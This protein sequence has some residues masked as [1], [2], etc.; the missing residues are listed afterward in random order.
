MSRP[1]EDTP[2]ARPDL[3]A[4]PPSEEARAWL[5]NE[6]RRR[7]ETGDCVRVE[8]FLAERTD[9]PFDDE[10]V[11]DLVYEEVAQREQLGEYPEVE[12]YLQRF[13][14]Q[15]E[16][17]RSLLSAH[18]VFTDHP[19]LVEGFIA[20]QQQPSSAA[21]ST[22]LYPPAQRLPPAIR[23]PGYQVEGELGRGGM[24]IVYHAWQVAL[25][26]R[27]ALKVIFA[28]RDQ[29]ALMRE[30][31]R[32]E[33]EAVARLPHANVVPIYEVGEHLGIAYYSME[34]CPGGNLAG[35]LAAT[36]Q[37]PRWSAEV[38]ATL[39][40]AMHY[41][42]EKG[43]VHDD[44]KPANV[45]LAEDGTV[46]LGD[47]GLARQMDDESLTVTWEVPGTP[48]YM[49]PEQASREHAVGPAVDIYALGAILYECLTGRPPFKA[50]TPI[51][52]IHQV[53]HVDPVPPRRLLP[54]LPADLE[55]ICLKC[56][57]KDPVRRYPTALALAEE[58]ERFLAGQP[59]LAR[60][61]GWLEQAGKWMRRQPLAA[62]LIGTIALITLVGVVGVSLA[63]RRAETARQEA[64]KEA[65]QR[66]QA[67]RSE[68]THRRRLEQELY[69]SR[70]ALAD[71]ELGADKR[72]RALSSLD[73]CP[74]DFR[75]WEWYYLSR[76]ARG[77][78]VVSW[79]AH[80]RAISCLDFDPRGGV[81]ASGASDG[82]VRLWQVG[83]GKPAGELKG[84]E[85]SVNWVRF[86][87]D[88][89]R[90][91][92]AGS[93]GT[94]ILWQQGRL[95]KRLPRQE[96][97]VSALAF[98][99]GGRLL[100]TATMDPDAPGI[101]R[102][103]DIERATEVHRFAG[104]TSMITALAYSADGR[105]LASASRDGTVRLLAGETAEEM[106]VFREHALAVSAV[107][108]SPDGQLVASAAGRSLAGR[109]DE[110]EVLI[111][112]AA[113]GEVV[114]RLKG[115]THRPT[116]VAFNPSGTRLATAGSDGEVK[117]WDVA[118]GQEVLSLPAGGSA[119]TH[120]AFSPD[121]RWLAAGGVDKQIRLWDGGP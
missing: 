65:A 9:S 97:A 104:H 10:T 73:Q 84:H 7:W 78:A 118:G 99:P 92:S 37:P 108:F 11:I 59:I 93:D 53:T 38:I 90:L 23:V 68:A 44:L 61:V 42:H 76:S 24:G 21:A 62:A 105:S 49:A 8:A 121:G 51:E 69:F 25:K 30:R 27:V 46:K 54:E 47:F 31:F 88:G 60:P 107:A 15:A 89:K 81:L 48:Y 111:W 101:V 70:I 103:W 2:P 33:I 34:F 117:L 110:G 35:Q 45:L 14:D 82:L 114:H 120:I 50:A 77:K 64:Q 6:L 72:A 115:H 112:R 106:L 4:G 66:D 16:S 85:G 74:E 71:R 17:L 32:R 5:R 79:Q 40:R 94:V 100:A 83:T 80:E 91:A 102:L 75:D 96:H 58:L 43:I 63:W 113:T 13:P 12:E 109:L 1:S 86:S 26:R 39:A 67:Y 20:A 87:P 119:V 3:P 95:W 56:L 28:S 116:T 36:P 29:S 52:T 57:H 55:T 22:L 19:E 18:R 41:M 98:H